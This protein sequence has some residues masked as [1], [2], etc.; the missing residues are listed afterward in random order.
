MS[1]GD[2]LF[3]DYL[4]EWFENRTGIRGVTR[5]VYERVLELILPEIGDVMLRS[6]NSNYLS[7][8]IAAI[9]KQRASY[10]E[11]LYELLNMAIGDAF[12]QEMISYNPMD[13]VKKPARRKKI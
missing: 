12:R 4:W 6:V 7:Q 9:A 5:L 2:T 3:R 13:N 11:K 8:M 10:G 1:A